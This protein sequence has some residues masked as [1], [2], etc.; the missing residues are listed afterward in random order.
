MGFSHV[1]ELVAAYNV[2]ERR[3]FRSRPLRRRCG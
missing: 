2:V 3:I 1:G